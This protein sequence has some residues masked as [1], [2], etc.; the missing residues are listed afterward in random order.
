VVPSYVLMQKW[1][2]NFAYRIDISILPYLFAFVV[3]FL[4]TL[5]VVVSKAFSATRI[6]LLRFLKYE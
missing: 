3:L 2:E 6:N 1:L 4:L 5:V